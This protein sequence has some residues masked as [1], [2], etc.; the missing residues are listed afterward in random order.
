MPPPPP[1]EFSFIHSL[2]VLVAFV[3]VLRLFS[4]VAQVS[5]K[6]VLQFGVPPSPTFYFLSLSL[7]GMIDSSAHALLNTGFPIKQQTSPAKFPLQSLLGM[8][9]GVLA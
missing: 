7:L 4:Y 8:G 1:D 2:L 6:L 9:L 5:F 3:F